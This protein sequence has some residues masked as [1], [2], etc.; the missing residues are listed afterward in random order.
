MSRVEESKSENWSGVRIGV[1]VLVRGS[2]EGK[3]EMWRGLF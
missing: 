2:W 1:R 3:M